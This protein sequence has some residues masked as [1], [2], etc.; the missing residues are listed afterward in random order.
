MPISIHPTAIVDEGAKVGDNTTIW[1]WTH[2]CSGAQIGVNC[3]FGQNVFIGND[4]RVGNNVKVQ[5]NVSIYD[6][7]WLDDDVFCGPS[8]VFTNVVNPRAHISRKNEFKPTIVKKGATLGA[9]CTI[10]CGVVI[11][12]YAFIAAGAVITKDVKSFALVTGVPGKQAGWISASGNILKL[13]LSGKAEEVCSESGKTYRL[14]GENVY[15]V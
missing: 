8:M 9:N 11:G 15:E 6:K 14:D 4:V 13:P 7:V 2:I 10:I 3:S 5:N 12:H 1:H